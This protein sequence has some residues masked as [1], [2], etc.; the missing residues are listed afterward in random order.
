MGLVLAVIFVVIDWLFTIFD[1]NVVFLIV[2][3]V[4][5]VGGVLNVET[6]PFLEYKVTSLK[7]LK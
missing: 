2:D 1:I 5:S 6:V 7:T 3:C 4:V